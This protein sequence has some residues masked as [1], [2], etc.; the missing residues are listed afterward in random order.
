M[1]CL[2]VADDV[3]HHIS[4]DVPLCYYSCT[5]QLL[6]ILTIHVTEHPHNHQECDSMLLMICLTVTD[7][8]T[9]HINE[10]VLSVTDHVPHSYCISWLS[11]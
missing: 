2:T 1:I 10:D 6:H 3:T 11:T 8:V 4:E 5:S 7:D 9:H